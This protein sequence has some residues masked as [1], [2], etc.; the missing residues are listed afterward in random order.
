[1][2][3]VSKAGRKAWVRQKVIEVTRNPI[4]KDLVGS[5]KEVGL[6]HESLQRHCGALSKIML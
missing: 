2:G 4:T 6:H 3:H 1:M 5:H